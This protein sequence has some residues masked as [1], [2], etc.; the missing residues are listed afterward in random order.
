MSTKKKQQ[1]VHA[2]Y[3]L[4]RT[5]PTWSFKKNLRELEVALPRYGVDEV[6]IK[7]DT[8]EFTHGQ[9][10]YGWVKRYQ[11]RLFEIKR[12]M[13]RLGI[14]F[15]INPWITVG[16]CDRGRDARKQVP[17]LRTV[18][19]HDGT[20]CTCCACPLSP[21]WRRHVAKIWR[22]Y[23][24]ARPHV[25]WVEDDIRT[26]NHAPARFG[27]F[28]PDHMREFSKR[29]GQPVT[30]EQLVAAMLKPG[31]PH[32]W[33]KVYLDMQAEFM[34]ETVSFLSKVVHAVSPETSLGLM[35]SG[36]R[37][38]C[39]E[40][41]RWKEFGLAMADGQPLYSRPPMGNYNE[42]SLRG[43]YYS[44]DSIKITRSCMPEQT[45]E[46]TEVE[47]V[48]FT[49]YSKSATFTFLEMA[50]SFA[51]GS[52][53]VTMNLFDHAGTPMEDEPVFGRI[54]AE[55]K[56]WL[57]A[58][59]ERA[60]VPGTYRGVQLL[61][62]ERSSYVKR[63]PAKAHYWGLMEDGSEAMQALETHGIA[64]TYEDSNVVTATGQTLRAYGDDAIRGM[65]KQGLLL[66]A[67]AAGVLVERGF[68]PD[69]GIK[70]AD[71]PVNI[72]T[73]G[74]FSAEEFNYRLFGGHD[75]D[76]LTLTIPGLGGR[77]SLSVMKPAP[78][79]KVA[80]WIVD[81][82]AR[83]HHPC[84]IAFRN[85]MGGRVVV[86]GLDWASAYGVAFNHTFRRRQLQGAVRWL[87]GGRVPLQVNGGVYPLAFRKDTEA[88]TL[89]GL[90]NLTL[91]AWPEVEFTLAD[92]RKVRRI[93]VL[94]AA[95]KWRQTSDTT[96]TR[97][98]A[99]QV[100]QCRRL[101][102]HDQPLMATIWWA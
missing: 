51:Y 46:Q 7:V 100:L 22:L 57:N 4:R 54:L 91:D 80:S 83:R 66:D 98:G 44:H 10:P 49:Q 3:A 32:P 13:D 9:P 82:D 84:M 76:Y 59:A 19:G 42:D 58:L 94:D 40:G 38:H 72:D 85:R 89:V 71:K 81:P 18:V 12:A 1:A 88:F 69:I 11:P 2:W 8:E 62:H 34:I 101:V 97:R 23:A 65:L 36:P 96:V 53:G 56:P 74:A 67:T 33:R 50:V 20:V 70:S 41:R 63:L 47:S 31:V 25:I 43:F 39:L 61:H 87:A 78:G 93:E 77:P 27:C 30:R 24:Q 64:T 60:Q 68:G 86:H 35:S 102:P 29:V 55:K 37:V 28:C 48:P 52:H 79:A 14:R 26:F 95:G 90:F 16:H 15:S 99:C 21:A 5:L 6:I 92:R 75:R 45:I 17:G 73:L